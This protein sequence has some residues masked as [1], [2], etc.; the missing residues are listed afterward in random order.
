VVVLGR[1]FARHFIPDL[2]TLLRGE[3]RTKAGVFSFLGFVA[4]LYL[5]IHREALQYIL[6]VMAP[7]TERGRLVHHIEQ[8]EALMSWTS[9]GV[10]VGNFILLA[11]LGIFPRTSSKKTKG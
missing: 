5:A 9:S 11:I 8:S 3:F 2:R 6:L 10:F 1:T 4:L 7:A